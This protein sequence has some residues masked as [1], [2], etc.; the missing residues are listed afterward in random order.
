VSKSESS[1]YAE[2]TSYHFSDNT[3]IYAVYP[4]GHQ[5][6]ELYI[7][8]QDWVRQNHPEWLAD[9]LKDDDLPS[10]SFF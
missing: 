6:H 1:T 8:T 10:G 3:P 5:E 4:A 2:T 7:A 9:M